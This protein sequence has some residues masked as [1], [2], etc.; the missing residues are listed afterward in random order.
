MSKKDSE[1]LKCFILRY[2]MAKSPD[3]PEHSPTECAQRPRRSP[4][5]HAGTEEEQKA[6]TEKQ[7][8]SKMIVL[9][10]LNDQTVLQAKFSHFLALLC[11]EEQGEKN[12]EPEER[13]KT[14]AENKKAEMEI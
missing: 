14:L 4:F 13:S 7:A 2:I 10:E 8:R 9:N 3:S 5:Y 1:F 11:T 6:L 12:K